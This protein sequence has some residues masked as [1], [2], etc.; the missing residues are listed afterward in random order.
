LFAYT[1]INVY[2]LIQ[3]IILYDLRLRKR[4]ACLEGHDNIVR[5]LSFSFNGNYLC[6]ASE[7]NTIRIWNVQTHQCEAILENKLA[8]PSRDSYGITQAIYSSDGE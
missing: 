4:I 5:S 7:D 6:S 1:N 8:K 3:D 2:I